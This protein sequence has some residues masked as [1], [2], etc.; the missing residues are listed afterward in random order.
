MNSMTQTTMEMTDKT[1]KG[2]GKKLEEDI[3]DGAETNAR[4]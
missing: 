4:E 1:K 2:V 3:F